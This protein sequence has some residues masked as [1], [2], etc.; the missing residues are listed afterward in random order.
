MKP[1]SRQK[2]FPRI[3]TWVIEDNDSYRE[4]LSE[5]IS[6]TDGMSCTGRYA[7]CEDALMHLAEEIPPDIILLDIGLPGMN[8]IEGIRKIKAIVPTIKIIIITVYDDDEKIFSAICAGAAGYLLKTSREDTILEAIH[9]TMAGGSPLNVHVARRVLGMVS[10]RTAPSQDFRLTN[11][12][13]RILELAAGGLTKKGIA[14]QLFVSHHTIDAQLRSI[15]TKLQVHSR[16]AA[17]AKA[18][19][20]GIL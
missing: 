11:R 20:E 15:Y 14:E 4:N 8:G 2:L 1:A 6:Q 17:I 12:E 16:A 5:L 3:S 7:T 19:K 13:L 9:Q 18:M 10:G